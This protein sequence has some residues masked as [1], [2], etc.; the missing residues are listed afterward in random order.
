MKKIKEVLY[1]LVK[2]EKVS[3]DYY[4]NP[5]IFLANF[6]DALRILMKMKDPEVMELRVQVIEDESE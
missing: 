3:E 1:D 2:D 6:V 5:L 4:D